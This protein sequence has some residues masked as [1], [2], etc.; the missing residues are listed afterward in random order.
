MSKPIV[1]QGA[2]YIGFSKV[3]R[4]GHGVMARSEGAF[5]K[6]ENIL[7][8]PDP[9]AIRWQT[10]PD[11]EIGLR[12]PDGPVA[13]EHNLVG[14]EDGSLFCTYR[15]IDGW[16]CGAY[17][18]DGGHSWTKPA[19]AEYTPGGRRIKHP[20]AA[21]FVRRL[22]GGRYIL[23]YH[24]N[25]TRWYNSGPTYGSRNVAWLLGGVERDGFIHWGQPEIVL[26]N[27]T[28]LR[29]SSYP[30]F[31]EESDGGLYI[32][33]TQKTEARVNEVDADLLAGLWS[34]EARVPTDGL[35]LDLDA[36]AAKAGSEH[37]H[38]ELPSLYGPWRAHHID[39]PLSDRG[40]ISVELWGSLAS[41]EVGSVLV[42]NMDEGGTGFRLVKGPSDN[43][44]LEL[45]D[46]YAAAYWESDPDDLAQDARHHVVA[47][48]DGGPKTIRFVVNGRLSDGGRA[49]SYGWD[50]FFAEMKDLTGRG[51]LTVG[52]DLS[53]IRLWRR[54]LRTAEALASYRAGP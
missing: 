15:T 10:L 21:N 32:V 5:L 1:H 16:N 26:Y 33:S 38:G 18:R 39:P 23:W 11:G 6:S 48:V 43:V 25:G 28:F 54:A 49:R 27:D 17:S 50:R 2:A 41:A 29:G 24:N 20:R 46:G 13:D 47:V 37:E 31:V 34:Q 22:S 44:R 51:R 14:L 8:E 19:Y 7:T 12:S 4:F 45:C 30:D 40:G 9:G 52:L 3:G 53:R 35:A 36:R 42:S